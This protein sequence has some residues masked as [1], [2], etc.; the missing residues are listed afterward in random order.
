MMHVKS[1][2]VLVLALASTTVWANSPATP[3]HELPRAKA[4]EATS[5]VV[6][7]TPAAETPTMAAVPMTAA[8]PPPVEVLVVPTDQRRDRRGYTTPPA[9]AV[10]HQ[11]HQRKTVDPGQVA[12]AN[13]PVRSPAHVQ[14]NRPA[15]TPE[16]V[17]NEEIQRFNEA[18]GAAVR[19]VGADQPQK[20]H[21][22]QHAQHK[23]HHG[24]QCGPVKCVI[25]RNSCRFHGGQDNEGSR[26]ELIA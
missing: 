1:L 11:K 15:L 25:N 19:G 21:R 18:G 22:Q 26:P 23:K 8:V 9:G 16:Q 6:P 4:P 20:T 2:G 3:H 17:R 13:T 5:P 7:A 12:A 24:H 14:R 10:V